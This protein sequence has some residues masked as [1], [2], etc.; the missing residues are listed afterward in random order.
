MT[1]YRIVDRLGLSNLRDPYSLAAKGQ[2]RIHAYKRVGADVTHP[3]RFVKLKVA[4]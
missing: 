3:D 2:V 1:G 4:V